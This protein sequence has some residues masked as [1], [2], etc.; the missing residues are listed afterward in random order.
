PASAPAGD[1]GCRAAPGGGAWGWLLL[2]GW[3]RKKRRHPAKF[4]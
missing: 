1:E 4:A 2:L 3:A